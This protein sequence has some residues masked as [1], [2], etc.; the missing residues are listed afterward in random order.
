MFDKLD[1]MWIGLLLGLV[2]P[3]ILLTVFYLINYT[4][5]SFYGFLSKYMEYNALIPLFS[6]CAI[7]NL[8]LFFLFI[9][10]EK[11]YAARGIIFSTLIYAIIVFAYKLS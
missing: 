4:H 11:Y 9:H 8:G 2:S 10:Y 7:V 6:L 1:K 5:I 3:V